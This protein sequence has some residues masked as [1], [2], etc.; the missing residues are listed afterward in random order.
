MSEE[1]A[2]AAA[3]PD[4]APA[5]GG[6]KKLMVIV[7][8]VLVVALVGG[9]AYWWKARAAAPEG[10]GAKEEENVERGIVKLEPFVVNLADVGTS[11][12]L[13]VTIELLVKDGEVAEELEKNRVSLTQ[14]R[15]AI[16]ELLTTQTS[17]ELVKTEGKAALRTSIK[18]AVSHAVNHLEVFDVLFSDFVVQF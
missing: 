16:L 17:T 18:E 14:A 13:R 3:K 4:A 1:K 6:K 15:S 7:G 9:G 10:E 2:P 11:R 8:G 5:K 12:Y